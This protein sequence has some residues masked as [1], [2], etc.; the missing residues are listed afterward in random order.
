[1]NKP[2][3]KAGSY[4]TLINR[5][6]RLHKTNQFSTSATS[7]YFYLLDIA[8]SA[9]W[10]EKFTHSDALAA[11]SIGVSIPTLKSAKN[12]L[13]EA[14]LIN[15]TAGG[16]GYGK[17]TVYILSGCENCE[18]VNSA[19]CMVSCEKEV[20]EKA[21]KVA[22]KQ[23]PNKIDESENYNLGEKISQQNAEKSFSN[24]YIDKDKNKI[25][26]NSSSPK[27]DDPF[28]LEDLKAP[29]DG[30]KRNLDGL[31]RN[32]RDLN[33]TSVEAKPIIIGSNYGRIGDPVWAAFSE[34]KRSNGAIKAPKRF[35]QSRL[36]SNYQNLS[37]HE[38]Y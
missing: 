27:V 14:G 35:I 18:Q 26:K 34:I 7:L 21:V 33:F 12:V 38:N 4:I 23:S 2:T 11:V 17:K 15:F 5:F 32:L 36:F 24:I 29:N 1:M 31:L 22:P 9:R 10:P 20:K 13:L 25:K 6:W 19:E 37:N 30:V 16:N 8:N 3:I 28:D